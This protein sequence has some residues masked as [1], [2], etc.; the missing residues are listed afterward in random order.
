M[1]Q[2]LHYIFSSGTAEPFFREFVFKKN[3]TYILE[4]CVGKGVGGTR[5]PGLVWFENSPVY[6]NDPSVR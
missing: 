3:K 5:A 2:I 4:M 6:I 1:I